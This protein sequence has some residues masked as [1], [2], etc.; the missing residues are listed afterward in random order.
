[1]RSIVTL[2]GT[3]LLAV[4]LTGCVAAPHPA[5]TKTAAVSMPAASASPTVEPIEN[6]K[7]TPA[8][9][10]PSTTIS[11]DLAYALCLKEAGT[12][13]GTDSRNTFNRATARVD[14]IDGQW[15]VWIEGQ[16]FPANSPATGVAIACIIEGTP[17]HP[18]FDSAAG[19]TVPPYTYD[20]AFDQLLTPHDD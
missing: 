17:E 7:P 11:A 1:M 20:T 8:P 13:A 4:L 9:E 5:P 6:P 16:A 15:R 10:A 18:F 2:T 19:F 14:F 12:Y 3:A